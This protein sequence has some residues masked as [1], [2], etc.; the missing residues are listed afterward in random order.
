MK[1]GREWAMTKTDVPP[2]IKRGAKGDYP[3]HD[4][5]VKVYNHWISGSLPEEIVTFL[6]KIGIECDVTDIE[7]DLQHVKSL[8]PTKVLIAHENDRNRLLLQ[9][10]EGE[11]YR[12]L[13][14][15]AL[16]LKATQYLA[17]GISPTGPLK[18][19][20]EAV[21]MT[22]KPGGINLAINQ[23]S[24]N[25]GGGEARQQ[26]GIRSSED[27]LRSVM[28]KMDASQQNQ[29]PSTTEVID[30]EV[31]PEEAP[32]DEMPTGEEDEDVI[33]DPDS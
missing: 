5:A 31:L 32:S 17:A 13:I 33:P 19:Y 16:Q 22:E 9:R 25:I 4:R 15:E 14:S 24:L 3:E 8:H 23:Q 30:A 7:C 27:L 11:Q 12:R 1:Q 10:T 2:L 26:T 6:N 21:G 18:E 20:R 29:L 28:D